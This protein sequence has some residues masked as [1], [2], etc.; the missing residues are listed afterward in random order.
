MLW[1]ISI[2]GSGG[3]DPTTLTPD[4]ALTLLLKGVSV[5]LAIIGGIVV[6]YIIMAGLQ[7]IMAG[8][9]AGDQATAKKTITY[10]LVGLALVMVSFLIVSEVLRRLS[11][12]GSV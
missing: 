3:V 5:A 4:T 6:V 11:F 1:Q 8:G 9:N 7:Y 10:A 2:F 12:V